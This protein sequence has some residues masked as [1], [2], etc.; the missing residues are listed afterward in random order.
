[1]HI[2][3]DRLMFLTHQASDFNS[4]ERYKFYLSFHTQWEVFFQMKF[5][6]RMKFYSFHPVSRGNRNFFILGWDFISVT[7]KRSL[8]EKKS[9][10]QRT[11][12]LISFAK[13][14]L[15]N[16]HWVPNGWKTGCQNRRMVERSFPIV[17][18]KL[19]ADAAPDTLLLNFD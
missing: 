11:I 8:I 12:W 3:F 14:Q 18:N 5:H 1:M 10:F 15:L 16:S 2:A 4:W 13:K 6:P 19:V 7:C 9:L 17:D